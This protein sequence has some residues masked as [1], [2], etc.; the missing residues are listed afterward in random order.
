MSRRKSLPISLFITALIGA[1]ALIGTLVFSTPAPSLAQSPAPTLGPST[2]I[3]KVT[4][5]FK[6]KKPNIKVA[7]ANWP[8]KVGQIKGNLNSMIYHTPKARYYS[9]TWENV[10]CFDTAA[11]AALAGFK[12]AKV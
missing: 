4:P 5:T 3:P 10:Q 7:P 1:S 6:G 12:P 2:P 11:E 8:C 9:V